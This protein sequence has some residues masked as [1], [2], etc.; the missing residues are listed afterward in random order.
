MPYTSGLHLAGVKDLDKCRDL[1]SHKFFK[2]ILQ[3]TS[4]LDNLLP[5]PRDPELLSRLRAPSK[6]PRIANRTKKYQSVVYNVH[7]YCWV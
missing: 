5:P 6:Y 4:C 2:S 1:L 7:V 3:P